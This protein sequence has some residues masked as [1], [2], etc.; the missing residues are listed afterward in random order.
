MCVLVYTLLFDVFHL[1][2]LHFWN[3]K[4]LQFLEQFW[5]ELLCC[6]PLLKKLDD[7]IASK[8]DVQCALAGNINEMK[9]VSQYD[10]HRFFYETK[11]QFF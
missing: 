3:K 5:S 9:G 11:L 8:L 2:S 4:C 6:V 7:S 1:T 10:F